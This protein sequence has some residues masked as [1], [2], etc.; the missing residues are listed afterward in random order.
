MHRLRRWWFALI[1]FPVAAGY[2]FTSDPSADA[3]KPGGKERGRERAESKWLIDR[4][5]T[6]APK[7]APL[8]ALKYRLLTPDWDRKPGNAVPIYLRL[9]HQ[10]N[11]A[12]RR[13]WVEV[14]NKWNKLALDRLPKEEA[15]KFL[16]ENR[17]MLRQL[18]LGARRR[19]AEWEYTLD[20]G[21]VLG[22]LMPELHGMR[23]Y[24]LLLVL[25]ARMAMAEG[26]P[27]E[28]IHT[29]ETGFGMARHVAESPPMISGLVAV[30][31]SE[32]F[33]NS[34]LE[35]VQLPGAPNLYWALTALPRPLIGLRKAYEF[36]ERVLHLQ[37]P[38]LADLNRPRTAG[39]WDQV[40]KRLRAE[41]KRIV[42]LS[43]EEG[44]SPLPAAADPD[45]P[46]SKSP[47]LE[48]ARKY[49]REARRMSAERVKA[50]PDA[51][52]LVLYI[53]G[54]HRDHSDDLMKA[55]YLPYPEGRP[56]V[57]A[58]SKRLKEAPDTE[59]TRVTRLFLSAVPKVMA[60][61]NRLDRRIA[62]LRVI[63]ALRLHAA[64]NGG[65]LPDR[66][67]DVKVVPLPDDPGTGK[68]F[69]YEHSGETATL[70]GTIPGTPGESTGIRYRVTVRG[71]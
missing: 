59:A 16:A 8:P 3:P 45:Q 9:P 30:N 39:Q 31:M 32:T 4:S 1:V 63:E 55:T 18:E 6:V 67:S 37:M 65:R 11:D 13:K 34:L 7:A 47:D 50:M 56:V 69:A 42:A 54:T 36:E 5:L 70:T 62:A 64:A 52:V 22:L 24:A 58:A 57:E 17:Y 43:K 25:Q 51:Q 28:A 29:L 49:L 2:C 15:K 14:P 60:A 44:S 40:L 23:G 53:A 71:K 19:T 48:R 68:P 66:L 26:K 35:L 27:E 21:D 33:A 41:H 61:Q 12:S 10:Q 46:A 38:D 20:A